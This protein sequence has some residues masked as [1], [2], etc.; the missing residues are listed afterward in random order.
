VLELDEHLVLG[1][2]VVLEKGWEL[3]LVTGY[4]LALG[5]G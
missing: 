2:V 5:M 4:E 3:R 1:S